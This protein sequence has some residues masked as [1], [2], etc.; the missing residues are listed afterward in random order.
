MGRCWTW[1]RK[2]GEDAG[3]GGADGL[4]V[5]GGQTLERKLNGGRAPSGKGHGLGVKTGCSGDVEDDS[6]GLALG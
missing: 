3:P 5:A 4:E 6:R 2:L 1:G